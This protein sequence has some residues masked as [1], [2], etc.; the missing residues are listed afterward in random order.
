MKCSIGIFACNEEKN[1]GRLLGR[2]L[3]Q[4]TNQ[5]EIGEVFV[6]ASGCGDRTVPIAQ[7]FEKR[8]KRV[9]VLVQGKREGKYSAINLFLKHAQNDILVM[10]S[11]DTLPAKDTVENLVRVF[12][13]TEVGMA[14]TRP[15][16][17]DSPETFMGFANHLLWELHHLISFETPKTGEMVAF[18]KVF[19]EIRPTAVDEACIEATIKD[20]G[21]KV[22]YVPEAIVYN[23]GAETVSDFLKQRRRIFAGHL[24][25][26]N[27]GGYEVSTM[28]GWRAFIALLKGFGSKELEFKPQ[29]LFFTPGVIT[30]EVLGRVLGWWDY[31]VKRKSHIIWDMAKTTR[32][33]SSQKEPKERGF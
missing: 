29:Y 22:V 11:A 6:V 18:R 25:L 26:K 7:S 32:D 16:P 28:S 14:G 4:K 24:V 10:E 17:L 19:D 23:K 9:K 3:E 21:F 8:D 2:V 12:K 5:V 33:L 30:L 31:Y 1:I 20:K 15:V 27:K 13:D